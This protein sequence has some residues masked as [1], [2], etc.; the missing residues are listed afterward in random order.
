[1]GYP[2]RVSHRGGRQHPL[3]L[4]E[5]ISFSWSFFH[6]VYLVLAFVSWIRIQLM[7]FET[8]LGTVKYFMVLSPKGS[9]QFSVRKDR[10]GYSASVLGPRPLFVLGTRPPCWVLGLYSCWALSLR[11]GSSAFFRAFF[12]TFFFQ[13]FVVTQNFFINKI[14]YL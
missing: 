8:V 10:A 6:P 14:I 5:R 7:F 2:L 1:M 4:V 3:V 13:N 9:A 11:A 12:H